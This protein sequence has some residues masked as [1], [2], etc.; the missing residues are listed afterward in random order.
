MSKRQACAVTLNSSCIR[1][2]LRYESLFL[3]SSLLLLFS[4]LR[5]LHHP[6]LSFSRPSFIRP[7]PSFLRHLQPLLLPP[8]FLPSLHL[9][10]SH[11]GFVTRFYTADHYTIRP[12]GDF[13]AACMF[14]CAELKAGQLLTSGVSVSLNKTALVC[15]WVYIYIWS[16]VCVC[17]GVCLSCHCSLASALINANDPC[18]QNSH[19]NGSLNY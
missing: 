6:S 1:I 12:W 10:L 17:S 11:K 18:R 13:T 19:L 9:L 16:W 7:L 4:S 14:V 3:S 2:F 5:L 15:V 8:L